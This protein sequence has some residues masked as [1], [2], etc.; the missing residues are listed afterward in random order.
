VNNSP[1]NRAPGV[2]AAESAVPVVRHLDRLAI[3]S[4]VTGIVALISLV[5][6][7][8]LLLGPVAA[9]MGFISLR[10]IADDEELRGRGIARAGL[11]LGAV[12]FVLGLLTVVVAS[13]FKDLAL[14]Y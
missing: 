1:Q 12:A 6:F 10:R 5:I 3:A 4:L 14:F 11:I 8:G 13:G 9:I 2:F 7:L